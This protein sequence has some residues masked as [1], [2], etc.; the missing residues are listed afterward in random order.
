MKKSIKFPFW[1]AAGIYKDNFLIGFAVYVLY[2]NSY[3]YELWLDRF[4]IDEKYQGHEYGKEALLALIENI[5]I[6]F[7]YGILFLSVYENYLLEFDFN[8]S[9]DINGELVMTKKIR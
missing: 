4:F 7:E 1:N 5:K 8:E 3:Q 2:K 6:E 9:L